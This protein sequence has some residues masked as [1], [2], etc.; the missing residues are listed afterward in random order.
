MKRLL[1]ALSVPLLV[2]AGGAH[3]ANLD[4]LSRPGA[5]Q[6]MEDGMNKSMIAMLSRARSSIQKSDGKNILMGVSCPKAM[7]AL[8]SIAV[9][10]VDKETGTRQFLAGLVEDREE[11]LSDRIKGRKGLNLMGANIS[12]DFT[13]AGD[14][15]AE[16]LIAVIETGQDFL[17][18]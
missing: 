2:L 8:A 12:L 9:G 5:L 15:S 3:A 17:A 6:S 13:L 16:D 14:V 11:M 18:R 4:K 1:I 7:L 10:N